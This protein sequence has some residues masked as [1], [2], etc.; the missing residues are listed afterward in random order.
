MKARECE[1]Q[2]L[3]P[4]KRAEFWWAMHKAWLRLKV[5]FIFVDCLIE[6]WL[7]EKAWYTYGGGRH[8]GPS[9]ISFTYRCSKA[10]YKALH[11]EE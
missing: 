11:G 2:G 8:I 10:W 5:P 7:W 6:T 3:L 9:N 4:T 1:M